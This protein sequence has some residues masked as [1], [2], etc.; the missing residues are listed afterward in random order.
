MRSV[1]SEYTTDSGVNEPALQGASGRL[2]GFLTQLLEHEKSVERIEKNTHLQCVCCG[3]QTYWRC[4]LCPG[5]PPIHTSPP[6]GKKN[7]CFLHYHDTASFGK[8]RNDWHIKSGRKKREWKY[9]T[10]N[11]LQE[12]E[13]QMRRLCQ[14]IRAKPR[15]NTD[16]VADEEGVTARDRAG[17]AMNAIV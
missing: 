3:T 15:V 8:W 12:S 11:D 6:E 13:R 16:P 2:C 4:A 1:T 9:P 7:S 5:K 10:D 14:G 17:N